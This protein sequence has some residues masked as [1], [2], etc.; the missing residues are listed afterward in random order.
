[1]LNL[2]KK[3]QIILLIFMGLII[4][5]G[6]YKLA[7][8]KLAEK[9]Q[10][11]KAEVENLGEMTENEVESIG[12]EVETKNAD[13]KIMV[14]V[15]GAVE[16]PGVYELSKGARVNDALLLAI[17]KEEAYLEGI[18][19]AQVLEDED[20]I[21]VPDRTQ[22]DSLLT[23]EGSVSPFGVISR[24]TTQSLSGSFTGK[25]SGKVNI[26]TADEALLQTLPGIGPAYSKRIVE[27][28]QQH[29]A[30]KSIEEIKNVSGIGEKRFESLKDL[31][32]IN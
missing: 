3:E 30:F 14:H 16:Y 2:G 23:E 12:Q 20:K 15:V 8:Q 29:G 11:I 17:P 27:Y 5:G 25:S 26:N 10:V 31:I 13:I 32:T 7:E 1:M 28:R 24:S 22:K 6:G 19:L 18:N 9:P 21:I 4:F